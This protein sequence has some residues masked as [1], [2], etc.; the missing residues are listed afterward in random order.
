MTHKFEPGPQGLCQRTSL[1]TGGWTCSQPWDAKVH[2]TATM[3]LSVGSTIEP[4]TAL[5][6]DPD[7]GEANPITPGMTYVGTYTD[8]VS[9]ERGQTISME[10]NDAAASWN[11]ASTILSEKNPALVSA[12]TELKRD[13]ETRAYEAEQN[14]RWSRKQAAKPIVSLEQREKSLGRAERFEARAQ[15]LREAAK[16]LG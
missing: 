4:G 13:L 14:A 5:G 7:T 12:R 6:I 8:S 16:G 2:H 11:L 10:A 1:A 9:A 3:S 15:A